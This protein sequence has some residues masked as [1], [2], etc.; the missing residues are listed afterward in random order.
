MNH[1]NQNPLIQVI[2]W[3]Q[4]PSKVGRVLF[5]TLR[6]PEFPASYS[7][8]TYRPLGPLEVNAVWLRSPRHPGVTRLFVVV[9]DGPEFDIGSI[10]RSIQGTFQYN[11]K[12][13][14]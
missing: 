11:F 12:H 4:T 5:D 8:Y 2:I 10:E 6:D 9:R 3:D 13:I 7:S 14:F 1:A